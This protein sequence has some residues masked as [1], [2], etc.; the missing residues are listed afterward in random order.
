MKN[1]Q[2]KAKAIFSSHTPDEELVEHA[3]RGD[4]D[5]FRIIMKHHNQR[6]F[7]TARSILKNDADAED[8]L[9]EAYLSAWLALCT[10]R[11]DAKLSTWLVRIVINES[12]ARLRRKAAQ[13]IP[14]DTVMNSSDPEVH[15]ALAAATDQWPEQMA[16]RTQL[17]RILEVHIDLLPDLYRP[18]FV[19]C[20]VQEMTSN[21]VASAL[22]I[23]EA[24]V[25]TRLARARKI[26]RASL[27]HDI[28]ITLD[29][30]FSFDGERCDRI[31]DAVLTRGKRLWFPEKP[32][33]HVGRSV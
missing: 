14:L 1:A 4:G 29:D 27:A 18:V 3:A 22:Q 25:R 20:A 9:Q 33:S 21:E 15:G 26:L 11:S 16:M 24:T 32:D 23:P 10:F 28:D 5:A 13:I 30:A 7:R 6:L 19:L 31:T 2:V 17:R 8:A 12:L